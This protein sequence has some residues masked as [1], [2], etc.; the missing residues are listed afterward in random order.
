MSKTIENKQLRFKR[1]QESYVFRQ[2]E[3]LYEGVAQR[4]DKTRE[5]LVVATERIIS[6]NNIALMNARGALKEANPIA[7]VERMKQLVGFDKD[8]LQTTMNEYLRQKQ[9]KFVNAIAA[10]DHLSPLK[11]MG[12]GYS[13]VTLDDTVVKSVEQLKVKDKID[14]HL[15]DGVVTTTVAEISESK[16][17]E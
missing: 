1:T 4:L 8:K 17:E 6:S 5:R 7:Q 15:A 13:Y 10:L 9:H 12:R 11:I 3:R 16:E 14:V 2:P